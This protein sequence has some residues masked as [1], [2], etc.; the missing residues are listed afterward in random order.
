MV[1]DAPDTNGALV[2]SVP[3]RCSNA[4]ALAMPISLPAACPRV[5]VAVS[6]NEIFL[7]GSVISP[8]TKGDKS[9]EPY[10]L[11]TFVKFPTSAGVIAP[12]NSS[13]VLGFAMSRN[14]GAEVSISYPRT[15]A[16]PGEI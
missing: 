8:E 13:V 12:L 11:V 2:P 14:V 7:Y 6:L 10:T 4:L 9:G 15:Y 16:L 1:A 5:A 3:E